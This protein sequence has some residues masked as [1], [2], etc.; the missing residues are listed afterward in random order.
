MNEKISNWSEVLS[1]SFNEFW[2]Q[3]LEMLPGVVGAFLIMLIGWLV[4]RLLSKLTVKILS[5]MKE[6][7]A[8]QKFVER[9]SDEMSMNII[10]IISKFVYW[11][12]ILL[13]LVISAES[14]GWKIVSQEIG[15][16]FR[17][18]P[19]LFSGVIILIIG[20]YI[21]K[22]LRDMLTAS[23]S[24]L[25]MG[26]SKSIGN[27]VFYVVIIFVGITALNQ[28]GVDT[29]IIS[30]NITLIIGAVLLSFAIA[31]GFASRNV[32]E[33]FIS[34][35]YAR[36]NLKLGIKIRVNN[37]EGVIESIDSTSVRVKSENTVYVF[38]IKE[39]ANTTYQIIND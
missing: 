14:L 38:P 26:G 11:V 7:K 30:Q 9:T 6:S 39:L 1:H 17:Y 33:N 3:F 32:L 28:V 25:G 19:K 18:L 36:N 12:I 8:L 10:N 22:L 31:F 29:Q 34:G 24:G 37:V 20:L 27:I 35:S 21:A 23:M 15:L 4:A 13:F 2:S 5:K 16:L